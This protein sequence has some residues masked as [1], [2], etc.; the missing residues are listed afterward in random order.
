MLA[1]ASEVPNANIV[2]TANQNDFVI[3][4]NSDGTMENNAPFRL[5]ICEQ[6]DNAQFG[7]IIEIGALGQ[8]RST[9]I[10]V[11]DDDRDCTPT[12]NI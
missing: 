6:G 3:R 2:I 5:A 12:V 8:I 9:R 1:S 4:F 10:N 7:R 11:D